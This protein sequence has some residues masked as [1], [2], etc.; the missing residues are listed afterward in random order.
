[1]TFFILTMGIIHGLQSGFDAAY[2]MTQGGPNGAS[3][4]IGY[5]IYSTAYTKFEMGYASAIAWVLFVLVLVVTA[6]NWQRNRS[7]EAS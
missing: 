3:T 6:Y 1:V 4:M 2:V 7:E 5:Y